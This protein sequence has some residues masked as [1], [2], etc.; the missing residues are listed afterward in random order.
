MRTR[1]RGRQRTRKGRE[2]CP[3]QEIADLWLAQFRDEEWVA[4]SYG[5]I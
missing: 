4:S 3:S 5:H 1:L 2:V